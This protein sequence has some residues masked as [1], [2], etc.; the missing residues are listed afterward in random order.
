MGS[1]IS[2]TTCVA[3][4]VVV[5]AV[6][7][8]LVVVQIDGCQLLIRARVFLCADRSAISPLSRYA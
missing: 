2:D 1:E 8:Q 3:D 6:I 7:A 4:A 5:I